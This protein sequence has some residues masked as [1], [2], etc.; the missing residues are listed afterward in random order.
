MGGVLSS[1]HLVA[2]TDINTFVFLQEKTCFYI[3]III[4]C[5]CIIPIV[6]P[7]TVIFFLVLF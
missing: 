3:T 4:I 2:L 7:I 1:S 6:L 5:F